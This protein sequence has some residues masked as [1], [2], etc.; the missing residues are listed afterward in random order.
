LTAF[1]DEEVA[2]GPNHNMHLC[3]DHSDTRAGQFP[4]YAR[5]MG[6]LWG[7]F[8]WLDRAPRGRNETGRWYRLHDE[9]DA[10]LDR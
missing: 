9:Y 8:Q 5:G 10:A 4:A 7:V 3:W 6:V 1:T 2:N